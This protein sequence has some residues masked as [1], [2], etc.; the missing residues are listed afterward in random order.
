M[1]AH[2]ESRETERVKIKKRILSVLSATE[3]PEPMA[4]NP[5]G[6]KCKVCVITM[7]PKADSVFIYHLGS[8]VSQAQKTKVPGGY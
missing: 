3:G 8:F 1:K 6:D 4:I 7:N 2:L 5:F